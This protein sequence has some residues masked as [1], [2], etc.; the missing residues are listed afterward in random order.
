MRP[1][2]GQAIFYGLSTSHDTAK[3]HKF[4]SSPPPTNRS[5]ALSL[6]DLLS[7]LPDP[8][9]IVRVFDEARRDIRY[10]V[11]DYPIELLI[12]KFRYDTP[13]EG[14]L[15]I[16]EYQRE[17]RWPERSQSYFIESVLLRIPV[18]PIFLY[19]VQGKL[20]IV[21]GSQRIRTLVQFAADQFLLTDLEK[22]DILNG[23]ELL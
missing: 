16:P 12:N 1:S 13:G 8:E 5:I 15:Y 22:L 6:D 21:D 23:N 19:E 2:A 10:I 7:V 4:T 20:E 17:L 18:P 3:I 9:E 14:D 11:T